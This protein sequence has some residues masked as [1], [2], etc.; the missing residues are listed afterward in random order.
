MG[1]LVSPRV[2]DA[3]RG[4][5]GGAGA[6]AHTQWVNAHPIR[7][8]PS[9][10]LSAP[11]DTALNGDG[12]TP[13]AMATGGG[14]APRGGEGEKCENEEKLCVWSCN[15]SGQPLSLSLWPAS[16]LFALLWCGGV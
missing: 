8:P 2:R 6:A 4:R 13:L 11:V 7:A 16:A 1:A 14:A 10:H 3:W 15:S 9:P 5:R 12:A